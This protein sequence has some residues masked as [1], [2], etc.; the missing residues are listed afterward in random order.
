MT[1]VLAV[2]NC[3]PF[4]RAVPQGGKARALRVP[5]SEAPPRPG[6]RVVALTSPAPPHL[7]LVQLLGSLHM[8]EAAQLSGFFFKKGF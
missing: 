7:P 5:P 4:V 3:I 2:V 6:G 1:E 8:L